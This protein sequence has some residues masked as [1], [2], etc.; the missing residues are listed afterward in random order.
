M[1]MESNRKKG[2]KKRNALVVCR[3]GAQFWTTQAQFW[4]WCRDGVLVKTQDQPLTGLFLRENEELTVKLSNT[5]LNLSCPNH[6]RE[7]LAARRAALPAR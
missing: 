1:K 7:S 3:S 4:Q 6:L 5:L 2:K